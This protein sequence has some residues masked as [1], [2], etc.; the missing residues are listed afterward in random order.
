MQAAET[1]LGMPGRPDGGD[2]LGVIDRLSSASGALA[3]VLLALFTGIVC[4]D[5]LA[6][7][8]FNA[9]TTWATEIGTYLFVALVFLGLASAQRANAHVQVE[10]LVDRLSPQRRAFAESVG[11]WLAL[12]FV[13]MCAWQG[14]RFTAGEYVNGTR[15]WG[16]LSTPQW[17]PQVPVIV[18]YVLLAAALLRDIRRFAPAGE[19]RA[20]WTLPVLAV[21]LACGLL[22]LGRGDVRIAGTRFDWGTVLIVAASLAGMLAWSGW[23]VAAV[24]GGF[25]LGA[26]AVF[27]AAAGAQ[28]TWL[29]LLLVAALFVLLFAG[30][31]VA[32]SMGIVGMLGLYFLL[33]AG[34][35]PI[36]AE[37]SWTSINT[38]TLTAVPSFVL[39][40]ALLVRSGI[41]NDLFD[42][43]VRWFGRTPAGLAH[44][45]VGAS[46]TFAAVCGSSLATAATL[47]SVAAPEMVRRGY[48]PRLT[49][50][51]IGA[52]ATLGILIPPSIPL[53]IYGNVVGAPIT[54][55]FVG[56]V[57][58]GILLSLLMMAVVMVWALLVRSSVPAGVAYSWREKGAALWK[59]LPFA[60]MISVVLGSMYQGVATPTEAGA[61]GSLAA[62]GMAVQRRKMDLAGLYAALAEAARVTAFIMMIVVGA[63]LLSYVFDYLRLPRMMVQLVTDAQLSP[64]LVMVV[65]VLIYLV[66]GCFIE[67]IAMI[68]MTLS[69]VFPIITALG[70]DPVWFGIVLVLLVEIGLLTP[71]VGLVLFVLK[72]MSDSVSLRDIALGVIPFIFLML[73]FIG[74]LYAFPEIVLWLPRTLGA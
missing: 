62:L 26:G 59:V 17:I 40:G 54:K 45:S 41:T 6:R 58:P 16:L 18:G 65:I 69:V 7:A 32:F 14:V 34:Q 15:D 44:A 71:P 70:F 24:A 52:G 1:T 43:L 66:L 28:A 12:V 50:G 3:A 35:L 31:R 9:G 4:Y 64:G 8:V 21:A 51:V 13:L 63:A 67:S 74:L 48:G 49:Y 23:R 2:V 19:G 61:L 5:V 10:I 33:P 11:L 29:G 57:V 25:L 60:I 37:R 20:G 38:F 55:L 27:H 39:M 53:I 68:L 47:G 22:L 73:A 56:G 72:G 36:L 30:V 46:A 42:A